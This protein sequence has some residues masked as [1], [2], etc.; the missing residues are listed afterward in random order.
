MADKK[1]RSQIGIDATVQ[2][3][4][5]GGDVGSHGN[6]KLNE[7]GEE[8]NPLPASLTYVGS[9]AMHIYKSEILN[10][11]YFVDQAGPTLKDCP[12]YLAQLAAK[13]L[14]GTIMESFGRKRP[15]LR[16]GF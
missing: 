5:L 12:E 3:E 9:A 2:R 15:K 6:Q 7:I 4:T 1:F 14:I 13:S 16:S 8:M 10:Q 11:I